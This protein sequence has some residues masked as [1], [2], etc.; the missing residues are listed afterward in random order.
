VKVQGEGAA[1]EIARAIYDFNRFNLADVL[2]VGRG[3]GSFED[4][5]PFSEEIVAKAIH[6]S[7]IPVISA[8]GHETD[9]SIADFVADVRAPTPSAAAEIALGERAHVLDFLQKTKRNMHR[10]LTLRVN[11]LQEKLLRIANHPFLKDPYALLGLKL[12]KLDDIKCQI[13]SAMNAQFR[14]K[15][16]V[17]EGYKRQLKTLNPSLI[18]AR[19]QEHLGRIT[20]QLDRG[21]GQHIQQEKKALQA[22]VSHLQSLDPKN[23][24]KKG[25][26]ILF[27]EAQGSVITTVSD[28]KVG[29]KV[30]AHLSEGRAQLL[31][32]EIHP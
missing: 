28:L 17:L 9:Y 7:L 19:H 12:Q 14:E 23:V 27:D 30:I 20:L 4:L 8:V 18:I 11:T 3:G 26:A 32:Q 29:S 31:T 24:L 10:F 6:E 13:E 15:K 2:I 1:L 5:F 25:Y 22:V 21:M 16:V